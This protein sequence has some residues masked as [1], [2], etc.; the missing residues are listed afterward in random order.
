M[1]KALAAL[2]AIWTLAACATGPREPAWVVVEENASV[3]ARFLVNRYSLID[4]DKI[5]IAVGAGEYYQATLVPAC[6]SQTDILAPVQLAE[7]GF[8]IDRSSA[9]I[10]DGRRCGI[11]RLDRVERNRPVTAAQ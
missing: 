10:I 7:T 11:R 5:L 4:D 9:F 3:P 6:A 1:L 8:G 2:I